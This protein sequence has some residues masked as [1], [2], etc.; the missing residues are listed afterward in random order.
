M[1]NKNDY[2]F[3]KCLEPKRVKNP[4]T[5]EYLIVPCGH[6][7]ACSTVKNSRNAF[8]M[9]LE[10]M[11][12][13]YNLFVTLTFDDR[14]IPKLFVYEDG[15][16]EEKDPSIKN[17]FFIDSET[18]E[19]VFEKIISREKIN[20]YLNKVQAT[21]YVP[22]LRKS[23]VQKFLKRFRKEVSKYSSDKVRYYAVGEYGPK[24]FRPHYHLALYFDDEKIYERAYQIVLKTWK[25]GRIDVQKSKGKSN[26]YI[27]SYVNSDSYL[28]E[29]LA[30]PE[31][32][33]FALHSQFL[34]QKIL[35][36][37]RTKA[38][39]CSASD[40]IRNG[41]NINGKYVEFSLWRSCYSLFF[42]KCKGFALSSDGELYYAYTI[43]EL[44]SK[45]YPAC[46][47]TYEIAKKIYE[48]IA[49]VNDRCSLHKFVYD[50]VSSRFF[51]FFSPFVTNPLCSDEKVIS[52]QVQNIYTS[53][54]LSKHFL[55]FVCN[56]SV[57][58]YER[59]EY[60]NKIKMFYKQLDYDRL[61]EFYKSQSAYSI[62]DLLPTESLPYWYDND[63]K[64]D[65]SKISELVIYQ[66]FKQ[67]KYAE[68]SSRIKHKLANDANGIFLSDS[69]K[70]K[71]IEYRNSLFN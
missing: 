62:I 5:N 63:L 59:M 2:P 44:A 16:Y 51:N 11:S 53:L 58:Y 35:Q 47:S 34:G 41:L 52:R 27:A 56:N 68:F 55:T 48:H 66:R 13:R 65:Y 60:I 40:F 50:D 6:C 71:L 4:Y 32:K 43:Y 26:N 20:D 69:Q 22:Y 7:E 70:S 21:D 38:Y 14:Y 3:V 9:N 10:S 67:R 45:R 36:L 17:Y 8:H 64:A 12:H 37:T 23:D 61:T 29:I 42:P 25:Y 33:P 39:S 28:P 49:F 18:G 31:T 54:L 1:S 19:I 15:E 24:H 46:S 57:L 30:N